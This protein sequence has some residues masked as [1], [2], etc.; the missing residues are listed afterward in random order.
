M[1]PHTVRLMEFLFLSASQ[2]TA[3]THTDNPHFT[4]DRA[5]IYC[6]LYLCQSRHFQEGYSVKI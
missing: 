5:F 1:A 4:T 2:D 6:L 3:K